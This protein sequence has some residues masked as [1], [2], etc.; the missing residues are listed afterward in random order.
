MDD[1][2][3]SQGP[4]DERVTKLETILNSLL[5]TSIVPGV[6]A[7]LE[8][9]VLPMSAILDA[10]FSEPMRAGDLLLPNQYSA[11]SPVFKTDTG[12][13]NTAA[14]TVSSTTFAAVNSALDLSLDC[15]GAPVL[16][17]WQADAWVAGA[18][19][20]IWGSWSIDGT[21]VSGSSHGLAVYGNNTFVAPVLV[22]HLA[23]QL[24]PGVHS[25]SPLAGRG[26]ANGTINASAGVDAIRS[27]AIELGTT[28][29]VKP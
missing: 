18:G 3:T 22:A 5:R 15:S 25:F 6:D 21:E 1:V 10:L 14:V 2:F 8:P 28:V 13:Y 7:E 20:L 19:G 24:R 29:T 12:L 27:F 26:T 16:M 17:V 23:L 4:V 9:K 11:S